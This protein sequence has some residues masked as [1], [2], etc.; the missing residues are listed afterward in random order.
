LHLGRSTK[1]SDDQLTK[2]AVVEWE[3]IEFVTSL[4]ANTTQQAR[5]LFLLAEVGRTA[6]HV[7]LQAPVRVAKER[8]ADVGCDSDQAQQVEPAEVEEKRNVHGVAGIK[9]FL[10]TGKVGDELYRVSVLLVDPVVKLP[11]IEKSLEAAIE[12]IECRQ[13]PGYSGVVE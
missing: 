9:A 1:Q 10:G 3:V 6:E 8:T 2:L 11:V 7:L 5:C 12:A 13:V 4:R